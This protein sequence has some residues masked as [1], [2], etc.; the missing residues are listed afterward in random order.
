[1]NQRRITV[2]ISNNPGMNPEQLL[3]AVEMA[4]EDAIDHTFDVSASCW[5]IVRESMPHVASRVTH[6]DRRASGP[7]AAC[8][9]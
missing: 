8:N 9:E 4:D 7:P 2:R 5:D 1:M 3:K 6:V